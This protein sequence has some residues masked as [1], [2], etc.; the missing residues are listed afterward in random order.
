[1]VLLEPLAQ[2]KGFYFWAT[3]TLAQARG[4]RLSEKSCRVLWFGLTR[5]L[6]E[7]FGVRRWAM[8]DLA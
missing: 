2:A 7:C 1:M 3:E 4:S 6:G 8:G 5:H